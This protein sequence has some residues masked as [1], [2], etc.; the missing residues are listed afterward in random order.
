[1]LALDRE[2]RGW[3]NWAPTLLE[4]MVEAVV[5]LVLVVGGAGGG[6]ACGGMGLGRTCGGCGRMAGEGVPFVVFEPRL[7][8]GAIG[9]DGFAMML[10][11]PLP[12]SDI[13]FALLAPAASFNLNAST[14][15]RA[16]LR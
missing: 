4:L 9:F 2:G 12:D 15:A 16:R 5:L 14:F 6:C 8:V 7:V 11:L 3:L 10:E 1:M 13:N